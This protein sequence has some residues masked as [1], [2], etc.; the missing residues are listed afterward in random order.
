MRDEQETMEVAR[1]GEV[2]ENA[3]KAWFVEK[4]A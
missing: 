4:R 2:S 3:G 1:R